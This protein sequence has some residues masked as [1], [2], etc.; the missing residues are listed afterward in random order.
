MGPAWESRTPKPAKQ[1]VCLC[2]R[3]RRACIFLDNFQAKILL[4]CLGLNQKLQVT[5]KKVT[6]DMTH[7][8]REISIRSS[9][10]ED[11]QVSQSITDLRARVKL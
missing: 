2:N 4:C 7:F 11:K 6:T 3:L 5:S 1:A 9:G 10:N 8:Q